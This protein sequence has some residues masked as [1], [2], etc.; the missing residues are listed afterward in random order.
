MTQFESAEGLFSPS[1]DSDAGPEEVVEIADQGG[2]SLTGEEQTRTIERQDQRSPSPMH[3][4]REEP[5]TQQVIR[6][7]EAMERQEQQSLPDAKTECIVKERSE[8]IETLDQRNRLPTHDMEE[9][10][11]TK[12]IEKSEAAKG[13]NQ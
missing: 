3:D 12:R 11:T 9:E 6:Q 1:D 7:S 13:Q 5:V 10:P 2:P 8:A 4:M